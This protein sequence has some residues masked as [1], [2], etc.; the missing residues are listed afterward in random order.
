MAWK[1]AVL[2]LGLSPIVGG[3]PAPASHVV[4]EERDAASERW[5][6]RDRVPSHAILPVRVGLMQS[7]LDNAHE[8]LMDI[9]HP[10]SPNYGKHWTSD[11]VVE[12]FKSSDETVE[13]VRNWLVD[14]G[15]DRKSITHTG[16]KVWLAFHATTKQVESLLHTEY[17]EFE[18]MQTGG[19]MPAC[20]RYHVPEHIQ[21]HIDYIT[22]GIKLLAPAEQPREHQKRS[23]TKRQ[24]PHQGGPPWGK[25][26]HHGPGPWPKHHQ[27][28]Y[29]MPQNPK[30]NLSTCDLAITPACIAALYN[31]PEPGYMADPSNSMGMFEAE[32]EYWDQL[33]LNLFYANFTHWVGGL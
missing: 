6:K 27:P 16:N 31:I 28:P 22:P 9:A 15:I 20:E 21:Q 5:L 3:L 2:C 1:F 7:N 33:D 23:L 26:W 25:P 24:W 4:H 13:T 18:D 11:E 17:H 19:I 30:A 14:S 29:P 8:H 32:L 12:F 10:A